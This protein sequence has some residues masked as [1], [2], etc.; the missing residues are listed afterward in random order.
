MAR[1]GETCGAVIG[2]FMVFGIKYGR[3]SVEDEQARDKTY[4]QKVSYYF[5]KRMESPI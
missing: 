5:L 4:L 2:A 3:V 1:M